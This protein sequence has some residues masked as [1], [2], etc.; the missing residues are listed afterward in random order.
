MKKG[1]LQDLEAGLLG[2]CGSD[3]TEIIDGE[4]VLEEIASGNEDII[5]DDYVELD[6]DMKVVENI[7]DAIEQ[8]EV[9]ME[10][11]EAPLLEEGTE[12]DFNK[13]TIAML[14]A[15]NMRLNNL[16]G[17]DE[18][19]GCP[20]A[21]LQSN[22]HGGYKA[23][24]QAGLEAKEGFL[25]NLKTKAAAGF[26][27]MLDAIKKFIQKA[28]IFFNGAEKSATKIEGVLKKKTNQAPEG[29]DL[30]ATDADKKDIAKKFGAWLAL[31]GKVGDYTKYANML[32]TP[33]VPE[34][35]KKLDLRTIS[36][37]SIPSDVAKTLKVDAQD[38]YSIL[39]LTGTTIKTVVLGISA[40]AKDASP[41]SLVFGSTNPKYS[42]IEV[43][44]TTVSVDE[45]AKKVEDN[46]PS[47]ATLQSFASDVAG[48]A[49]A[50]KTSANENYSAAE[51]YSKAIKDL[52]ENETTKG[53]ALD[54]ISR[55]ATRCALENVSAYMSAMK[56][57]LWASSVYGKRYAESK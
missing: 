16:M 21:G 23:A 3:A 31:G 5:P 57:M 4:T 15:S 27:A 6:G 1:L 46:I 33:V 17:V 2:E 49:K 32:K 34:A 37:V 26:K 44:S 24:F 10:E 53:V 8:E 43:T 14:A 9:I 18:H 56:T 52:K 55:I 39:S 48:L 35:N 22:I 41:L 30:K 11:V 36:G 50:L 42:D 45:A 51:S 40:T 19:R 28:V 12:S 38:A 20:V 7:S 54:K 25:K 29:K 13:A 47:L